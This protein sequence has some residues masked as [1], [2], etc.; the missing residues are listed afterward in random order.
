[1]AAY[2]HDFTHCPRCH[3][4]LVRAKAHTQLS[5]FWLECSNPECNTFV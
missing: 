2:A 5:E 3:A 1:M 4:R